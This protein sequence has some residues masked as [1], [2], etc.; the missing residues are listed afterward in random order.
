ML[1]NFSQASVRP[2]LASGPCTQCHS[3]ED[4]KSPVSQKLSLANSFLIRSGTSCPL[5]ELSAGIVSGLNLCRSRACCSC[6]CELSCSAAAP[7]CLED[8]A[9]LTFQSFGGRD[10]SFHLLKLKDKILC[11]SLNAACGL[12][13]SFIFLNLT[14]QIKKIRINLLVS[15]TGPNWIFNISDGHSTFSRPKQ[16]QLKCRCLR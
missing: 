1:A 8:G 15:H 3:T 7:L 16:Q 6:L 13:W 4:N 14:L 12:A 10:P 9:A 5:P 11:L 2:A